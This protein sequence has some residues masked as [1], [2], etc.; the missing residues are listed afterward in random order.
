M[1]AGLM[2]LPPILNASAADR[3]PE[4]THAAPDDWL[5][6]A[7]LTWAELRGQVVLVEVWTYACWNCYR[8]IPWLHQLETQHPEGFRIVGVH[9]PELPQEYDPAKVRAKLREHALTFPVMLDNDYSYWK[10]LGNRYWPAFY[11]VDRQGRIR[12]RFQGETHP[13]DRNAHAMEQ[14][15]T[16]LLTEPLPGK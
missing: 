2:T 6:S 7:P 14:Q 16:E 5:N 4:F 11:L 8:S 13:G 9:T 3:V 12:G 15:I 1:L 10:A